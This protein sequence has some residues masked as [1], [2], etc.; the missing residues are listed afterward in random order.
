MTLATLAPMTEAPSSV[1]MEPVRSAT[2]LNPIDR[3][4]L[5]DIRNLQ[6]GGTAPDVVGKVIGLFLESSPINLQILRDAIATGDAAALHKTSHSWKSSSGM[7]GAGRL[8]ALCAAMEVGSRTHVPED[9]EKILGAI[10]AE[11]ERVYI[12]LAKEGAL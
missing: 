5:E 6:Q 2:G 12:A 4:V 7:L 11:Y 9:A 8:S 10:E 3:R 1:D